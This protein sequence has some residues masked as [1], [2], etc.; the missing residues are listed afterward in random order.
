MLDGIPDSIH[1]CGIT[2]GQGFASACQN[3]FNGCKTPSK[4][5]IRTLERR[6]R[7]E[8][9]FARQVDHHKKHVADFF[10]NPCGLVLV[11]PHCLEFLISSLLD[12]Y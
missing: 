9:K 11:R 2:V 10:S 5:L 8:A 4:L 7:V 12:Q 6:L 3:L 1:L